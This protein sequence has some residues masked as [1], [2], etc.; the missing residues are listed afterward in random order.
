MIGK[1]INQNLLTGSIRRI[2]RIPKRFLTLLSR[3]WIIMRKNSKGTTN[4]FD[5]RIE[6]Y[7]KTDLIICIS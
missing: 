2:L 6:W 7:V 1:R 5:I 4:V 3:N